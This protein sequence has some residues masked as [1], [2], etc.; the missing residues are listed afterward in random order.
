M[1]TESVIFGQPVWADSDATLKVAPRWRKRSF[2]VFYED[3]VYEPARLWCERNCRDGY[4]LLSKI[5]LC[6]YIATGNEHIQEVHHYV[7]FNRSSDAVAF[8][9]KWT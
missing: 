3:F 9:L 4:L 2:Q 7:E 1:P 8:R 5:R 6:S